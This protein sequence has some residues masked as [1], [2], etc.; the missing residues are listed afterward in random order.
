M[1]GIIVPALVMGYYDRLPTGIVISIGALCLSVIDT[2]GP[3]HHR[4]NSMGAGIA[5]IVLVSLI[6]GWAVHSPV[7]LGLFLFLSCFVFSMLGVYGARTGSIGFA[8]LLVMTL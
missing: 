1:I 3:V 7:I 4:R 5:V 8:G 6:T 2:P